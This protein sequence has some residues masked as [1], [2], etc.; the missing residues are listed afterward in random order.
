L[1]EWSFYNCSYENKFSTSIIKN[2][3]S[4][5]SNCFQK[6]ETFNNIAMFLGLWEQL[7]NSDFKPIEFDRFRQESGLMLE[8]EVGARTSPLSLLKEA[9]FASPEGGIVTSIKML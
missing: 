2:P 9:S 5:A 6:Q 1:E 8:R 3:C 4:I 7:S